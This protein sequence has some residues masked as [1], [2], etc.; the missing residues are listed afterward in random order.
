M[1][2]SPALS[3][4]LTRPTGMPCPECKTPIVVAPATLLGA[5]SISC[6]GCGLQLHIDKEQSAHTLK[7]L[8]Q[9]LNQ[10][11]QLESKVTNAQPNATKLARRTRAPR[12]R[13]TR[14]TR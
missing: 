4:N 5:Q 2:N 10:M 6:Q 7:A 12:R 9:Y 13:A 8:S 1:S 11:Q 14:S 3:M